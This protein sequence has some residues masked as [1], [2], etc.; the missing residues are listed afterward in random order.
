L[1]QIDEALYSP[2]RHIFIFGDRGVGKTSLAQTA[3]FAHQSSD[4]DPIIRS[5]DS[6]TTFYELIKSICG[7]IIESPLFISRSRTHKGAVSIA[8]LSLEAQE[9]ID[10]GTIPEIRDLN[11]AISLIDYVAKKHSVKPLVIIDEFDQIRDSQEKEKFANFLKQLGDRKINIKFIFCGIASSLDELLGTHDSCYRY[12][13]NIELP[14]IDWSARFEIIDQTAEAFGVKVEDA[15]RYRIAAISD[16]FPH[17]VH[18]ICEKLFWELFNAQDHCSQIERDQYATAI[19]MAIGGIQLQLKK[20]YDNAILKDTDDYKI[21]LWAVADH[22]DLFRRFEAIYSS[23]E[24][25]IKYLGDKPIDKTK[26]SSCLSALKS[27][28]CGSVIKSRRRGWY[29]FR[30][31]MLRGYVRLRAE[32]QDVP[33]AL[34][35]DSGVYEGDQ[36][37]KVRGISRRKRKIT[38][39]DFWGKR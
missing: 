32:D 23:Y 31:S 21:A 15:F 37:L 16:G 2:G 35:Y 5:C 22:S 18:L 3:A 39:S 14:R 10:S 13:A 36:F 38:S 24:R 20:A 1:R 26:F 6:S 34:D 17:Y 30:E 4:N 11:Y 27:K 12:I 19:R 7:S 28:N 8:G 25:I 33:L 29:E 9:K